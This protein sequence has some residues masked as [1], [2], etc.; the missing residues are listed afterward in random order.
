MSR[1]Y[2]LNTDTFAPEGTSREARLVMEK[3]NA[4]FGVCASE[5]FTNDEIVLFILSKIAAKSA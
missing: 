3:F 1:V 4:R 5:S 2:D